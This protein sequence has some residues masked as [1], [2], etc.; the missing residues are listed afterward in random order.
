[1]AD[2]V[3]G[4]NND[5]GFGKEGILCGRIDGVYRMTFE[6]RVIFSNRS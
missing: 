1:M 4:V 3:Y 2:G 6:L 5:G